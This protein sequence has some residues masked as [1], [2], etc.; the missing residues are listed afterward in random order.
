VNGARRN[1]QWVLASRPCGP[2]T[3]DQFALREIPLVAQ[4]LL[5][6]QVMV[7]NLAF[8]GAPTLRNW[9]RAP[10]RSSRVSIGIGEAMRGPG[11]VEVIE[12]ASAR[13]PTGS[14]FTSV[15]PWQDF[16]VLEPDSAT[17]PVIPIPAGMS[18]VDALGPFGVNALTAYFGLLDVGRPKPGETVVVSAAAGSVGSV[19]VQIAK[20]RGCRVIGIAG[21]RQKCEDWVVGACGADAAVD[22]RH[23]DVRARLAQMC[24]SG[25]DVFFDNVGGDILQAVM[26]CTATHA[27]IVVCGQLA[28]YDGDAPAPGPHDMMR[29]VYWRIRIQ[30]F[31]VGDYLD[32]VGQA[33][34]D[35]AAWTADG[36]LR[37]RADVRPGLAQLPGGLCDVLRGA[38]SGTLI[39]TAD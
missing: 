14:R 18:P 39:V 4:P 11:A 28:A 22:Y 19:A 29:V 32:R 9:I 35:L 13:W 36:R 16:A 1:R 2:L 27:R 30:G 25:V 21:G 3:L 6:G 15:T 5:P 37:Q 34:N 10:G 7:R 24:P 8:L 23:D 38:N 31:L 17:S 12:S 33:R 26:D 20:I